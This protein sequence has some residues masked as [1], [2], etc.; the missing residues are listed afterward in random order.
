MIVNIFIT[1]CSVKKHG[2]HCKLLP[3]YQR[4]LHIR[5]ESFLLI[6]EMANFYFLMAEVGS[7]YHVHDRND[8]L[9]SLGFSHNRNY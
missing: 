3:T 6:A 5:K 8:K 9:A 4:N 7:D 2:K 1:T